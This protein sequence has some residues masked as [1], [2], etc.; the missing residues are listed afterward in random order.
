VPFGLTIKDKLGLPIGNVLL[1]VEGVGSFMTDEQGAVVIELPDALLGQVII[2]TPIKSGVRLDPLAFTVG[3]SETIELEAE[4][5]QVPTAC[6]ETDL[7]ERRLGLDNKYLD[8]HNFAV[9][10]LNTLLERKT[11][12]P[13]TAKERIEVTVEELLAN[14]Q[15]V[16]TLS[17][18]SMPTARLVCPRSELS[19]KIKTHSR[20]RRLYRKL[21]QQSYQAYVAV[22]TDLLAEEVVTKAYARGQL[23]E[24]RLMQRLA[25]SRLKRLR[26]RT[27]ECG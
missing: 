18:T 23:K 10:S 19:C 13:L 1:I 11:S 5:E 14:F 3:D 6:K 20:S 16:Q 26:I 15:Q 27:A 4:R 12:A 24:A 9:V 17:S 22:I 21:I 2:I 7:S 8:L 25:L